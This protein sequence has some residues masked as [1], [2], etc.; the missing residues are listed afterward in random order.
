LSE[1]LRD[2]A[3]IFAVENAIEALL[4]R[5]S[6][7]LDASFGKK[8]RREMV[9][10]RLAPFVE[11]FYIIYCLSMNLDET[12]NRLFA[13]KGREHESIQHHASDYEVFIHIDKTF[14]A[15]KIEELD[16]IKGSRYLF[17][18]DTFKREIVNDASNSSDLLTRKIND[19]LLQCISE[20]PEVPPILIM[21]GS[22]IM[23]KF[24]TQEPVVPSRTYTVT[25][26]AITLDEI[27]ENTIL[28][29]INEL[30]IKPVG[31]QQFYEYACDVNANPV[32]IPNHFPGRYN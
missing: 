24:S 25:E 23:S 26:L 30:G 7:I 22:K 5:K 14:D 27:N 15:P 31:H 6:V 2:K 18:I 16:I 21:P 19:H 13:R 20:H 29:R 4:D 28:D 17:L 10:D 11:N 12:K 32:P 1:D 9:I 3:F 8:R